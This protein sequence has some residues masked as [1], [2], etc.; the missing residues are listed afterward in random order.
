[1]IDIGNYLT[2]D[3]TREMTRLSMWGLSHKNLE[4]SFKTHKEMVENI[5][6]IYKLDNQVT[7]C[8]LRRVD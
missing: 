2:G 3:H 5:E 7:Q 4:N 8:M 6:V 1:M